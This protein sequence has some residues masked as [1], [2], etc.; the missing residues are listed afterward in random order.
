MNQQNDRPG[1]PVTSQLPSLNA[2]NCQTVFPSFMVF[3]AVLSLQRVVL[4][5]L[6]VHLLY[7]RRFVPQ[8]FYTDPT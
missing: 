2:L 5:Q 1:T 7:Y 3:L 4:Y 6:S 8:S